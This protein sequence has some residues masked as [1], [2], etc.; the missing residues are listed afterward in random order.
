MNKL[1][2]IYFGALIGIFLLS[3]S[4]LLAQKGEELKLWHQ[5]H[6]KSWMMQV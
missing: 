1:N 5:E 4:G 2:P 6:A 3:S